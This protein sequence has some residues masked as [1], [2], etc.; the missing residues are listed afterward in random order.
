MQGRNCFDYWRVS[1]D[2][3]SEKRLSQMTYWN[4]M[5]AC[6][7]IHADT[8]HKINLRDCSPW[9]RVQMIEEWSSLIFAWI[10]LY[11]IW[12]SRSRNYDIFC[13]ISKQKFYLS[14]FNKYPSENGFLG[15]WETL[16]MCPWEENWFFLQ[17]P[18]TLQRP[19]YLYFCFIRGTIKSCLCFI[20]A[21]LIGLYHKYA[22]WGNGAS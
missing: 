10:A 17:K 8:R 6:A 18:W 1:V 20:L 15:V 22:F 14:I 13:F 21:L 19:F 7:C 9:N 5:C 3:L 12:H 4:S 16:K 2:F 11:Q